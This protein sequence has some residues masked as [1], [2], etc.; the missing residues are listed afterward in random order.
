MIEPVVVV[1]ELLGPIGRTMCP[2]GLTELGWQSGGGVVVVEE[3]E[4]VVTVF[5]EVTV[6]VTV[7]VFVELVDVELVLAPANAIG[8]VPGVT[9]VSAVWFCAYAAIPPEMRTRIAAA[10]RIWSFPVLTCILH[11]LT[12]YRG[13]DIMRRILEVEFQKIFSFWAGN[14]LFSSKFPSSS[15][16]RAPRP[17]RRT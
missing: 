4:V 10:V 13:R 2:T 14:G 16:W 3:E 5:V 11:R 15:R 17:A 8:A 1:V 9:A 12:W 7:L 6:L